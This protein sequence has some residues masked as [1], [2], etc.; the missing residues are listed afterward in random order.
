MSC[1]AIT[2]VLSFETEPTADPGYADSKDI[3]H[4]AALL[5]LHSY[6]LVLECHRW[7]AACLLTGCRTLR[8][9]VAP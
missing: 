9:T 5:A 4:A 3:D 1:G 2:S 8:K 6:S 7:M